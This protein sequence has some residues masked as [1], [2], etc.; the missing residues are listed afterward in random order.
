MYLLYESIYIFLNYSLIY[1]LIG[2]HSLAPCVHKIHSLFYG[3]CT[4]LN[5][6]SIEYWSM[7]SIMISS[8]LGIVF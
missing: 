8:Y 7:Y 6:L 1:I 4:R 2:I 5:W 3:L